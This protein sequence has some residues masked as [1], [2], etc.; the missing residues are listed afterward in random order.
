MAEFMLSHEMLTKITG[1]ALWADRAEEVA[2]NSLPASMTPDLKGLHYLTAPNMV[3]LDRS[4]K[5]PILENGGDMLSYNPYQYRCC[6]HNVSHAWPYFA[7]HLWMAT[8]G[9]G[10]AAVLYSASSVKAKV[11]DGT[12]V[13]ITETTDYP[14]DGTMSFQLAAKKTVRFP[15]TLRVPEWTRDA[16]VRLNGKALAMPRAARGWLVLDREW[17]NGDRLSVEFPMR[18]SVRTWTKN[19]NSVSVYRGPLAYSLKIGER[20]QQYGNQPQWPAYEVFATTP[21][22]YALAVDP[23]KADSQV[24]VKKGAMKAQPFTPEAA[25]IQMQIPARRVA[26]W[27]LEPNGLIQEVPQSPVKTD[28]PVEQITLIPM[29]CARLRVSAFPL[30]K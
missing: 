2:F 1:D 16:V 19:R 25:P 9:N 30:A 15:L 22:N 28:A 6:Q 7:E 17:R 23:G 12:E 8:P 21:W 29:G 11:G 27:Q 10:L 26:G 5:A 18:V 4:S 3:Q 24:K 13:Q 14:F 20:W